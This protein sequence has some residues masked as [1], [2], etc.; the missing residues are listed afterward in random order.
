[1]ITVHD[2]SP[3]VE[4]IALGEAP[5][6]P[7]PLES[8]VAA[9][10]ENAKAERPAGL[11]DGRIVSVATG[12]RAR[13]AGCVVPYRRL[14]AQRAKPGLFAGLRVRPLAVSGLLAGP[15][16][17]AF[18]RRAA[19][20]T[21]DPGQ[22]EL[23]PSGG[24]TPDCVDVS[25]KV[26]LRRQVLAELAEEAGLDANDVAVSGPFGAFEDGESHVVDIALALETPLS[27]DTIRAR[28]ARRGSPEYSEIAVV[29][30]S[31][32]PG[33]VAA[34]RRTLAAVSRALLE[35]KGLLAG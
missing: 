1:M 12:A 28:H 24:V 10:W 27:G 18:G 26:D 23:I 15:D 9:V 6:L 2:L 21:D 5:S 14:I 3:N 32:I 8:E 31:A 22:W 19:G 33:F 7:A 29:A 25:G 13:R 20:L 35:R 17:V 16:G 11:F 4:V 30:E 34:R